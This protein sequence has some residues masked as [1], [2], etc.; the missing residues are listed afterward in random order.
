M[1]DL[2]PLSI[3]REVRS[4]THIIHV[5]A[6]CFGAVIDS[7]EKTSAGHITQIVWDE[8]SEATSNNKHFVAV[9]NEKKG[10]FKNHRS[11]ILLYLNEK[12]Y[13]CTF[14]PDAEDPCF[15]LW[16]RDGKLHLAVIHGDLG[17]ECAL[18]VQASVHLNS[19]G[20]K[21]RDVDPHLSNKLDSYRRHEGQ[22]LLQTQHRLCKTIANLLFIFFFFLAF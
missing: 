20:N 22:L 8:L 16:G 13:F 12:S 4:S 11:N 5:F 19:G 17:L 14:V 2:L 1:D 7:R 21:F 9:K 15:P 6:E 10:N 18:M 3:Q